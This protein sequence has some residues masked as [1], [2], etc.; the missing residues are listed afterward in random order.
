MGTHSVLN[1]LQLILTELAFNLLKSSN[2]SHLPV[3]N[4]FLKCAEKIQEAEFVLQIC[5]TEIGLYN[6]PHVLYECL[7]T[8]CLCCSHCAVK[9]TTRNNN[10]VTFCEKTLLIEFKFSCQ[11]DIARLCY[12]NIFF[13]EDCAL[14][15]CFVSLHSANLSKAAWGALEKNGSQLMIR[16]YELG[17]LFLPSAFVSPQFKHKSWDIMKICKYL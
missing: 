3:P 4:S 16:S 2:R 9:I 6:Y 12:L 5:M 11:K 14:L 17:V 8:Y 13:I 7:S 15:K 10:Q 1:V